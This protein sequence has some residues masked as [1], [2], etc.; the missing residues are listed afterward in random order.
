MKKLI[1]KVV[2]PP[3]LTTVLEYIS[4][5]NEAKGNVKSTYRGKNY[6]CGEVKK[7]K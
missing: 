6:H 3:L 7:G 1:H 5:I 4:E 2:E